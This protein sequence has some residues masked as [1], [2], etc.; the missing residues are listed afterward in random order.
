MGVEQEVQERIR[1]AVRCWD[2]VDLGLG[3]A[4]D[5]EGADEIPFRNYGNEAIQQLGQE[6]VPSFN[7]TLHL[8]GNYT[9]FVRHLEI[10]RYSLETGHFSAEEEADHAYIDWGEIK[11][12]Q[13]DRSQLHKGEQKRVVSWRD[14]S[15]RIDELYTGYGF[16]HNTKCNLVQ[17]IRT[18]DCVFFKDPV[19][20]KVAQITEAAR[21]PRGQRTRINVRLDEDNEER[22][23]KGYGA[24]GAVEVELDETHPA[25][26]RIL[27]E[28]Q[29]R[30]FLFCDR[31]GLKLFDSFE[32]HQRSNV[33]YGFA[34]G[35]YGESYRPSRRVI[36]RP[37]H[38]QE[39][40]GIAFPNLLEEKK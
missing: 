32:A 23:E 33:Y 16:P 3:S 26:E 19:R 36:E 24:N 28:M 14:G 1:T 11:Y 4:N 20:I 40:L 37:L 38:F 13:K 22:R 39:A 15:F 21:N 27:A 5:P 2:S 18:S 9:G 35:E 17:M 31:R 12:T 30:P 34:N 8:G 10:G 25:Y 29:T 6:A 7:R